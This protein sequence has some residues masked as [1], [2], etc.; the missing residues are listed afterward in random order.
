VCEEGESEGTD[1]P[2]TPTGSNGRRHCNSGKY[3]RVFEYT[4]INGRQ[5]QN[6]TYI[7]VQFA[8]EDKERDIVEIH[9]IAANTTHKT[10]KV[11]TTTKRN[12][13]RVKLRNYQ[14]IYIG[15][16]REVQRV[17]MKDNEKRRCHL[18]QGC[19]HTVL[20]IIERL[21]ARVGRCNPGSSSPPDTLRMLEN[22]GS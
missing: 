1:E 12:F 20:K 3:W 9:T 19:V 2:V 21:R 7:W 15:K 13:D 8:L 17:K 11:T 18:T 4:K 6:N 16:I 5:R 14:Y 22:Q 10:V